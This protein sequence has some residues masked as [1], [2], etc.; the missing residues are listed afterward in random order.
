MS[1]EESR[2]LAQKKLE[3]RL[4]EAEEKV[5]NRHISDCLGCRR[6]L[7]QMKSLDSLLERAFVGRFD[8]CAEKVVERVR[9]RRVFFLGRLV[10]GMSVAAVLLIALVLFLSGGFEREVVQEIMR[11]GE[12]TGVEVKEGEVWRMLSCEEAVLSGSVLRNRGERP[13][14][15]LTTSGSSLVLNGQTSVRLEKVDEC[16]KVALLEGEVFVAAHKERFLVCSDGVEI[17]NRGTQFA[18]HCGAVYIQVVVMEGEVECCGRGGSVI[19]RKGEQV[20]IS[21]QGVPEKPSPIKDEEVKRAWY[22]PLASPS[23]KPSE[24]ESPEQPVDVPIKRPE[25]K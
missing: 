19:L 13:S 9:A 22:V 21:L 4:T 16:Y 5:L 17:R 25:P 3:R 18:V 6:Y 10:V 12:A 1:C 14:A 11:V 7:T 2:R 8:G 24:I 23:I 20:R 15:L